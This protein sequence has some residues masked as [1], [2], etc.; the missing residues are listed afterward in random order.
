MSD[1]IERVRQITSE[2]LGIDID[3]IKDDSQ[4]IEDL[5]ADS[6]DTVELV[7]AIEESFSIEIPDDVAENITTVKQAAEAVEKLLPGS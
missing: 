5:D 4:F 1:T 7:M 3:T 2:Q 6:L